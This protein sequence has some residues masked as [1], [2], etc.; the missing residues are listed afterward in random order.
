LS[1]GVFMVIANI[2]TH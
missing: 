1:D 2:V